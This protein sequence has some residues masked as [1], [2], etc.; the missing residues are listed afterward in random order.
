MGIQALTICSQSTYLTNLKKKHL[1][2]CAFQPT[3][4]SPWHKNAP[5]ARLHIERR[6]ITKVPMTIWRLFKTLSYSKTKKYDHDL[7]IFEFHQTLHKPKRNSFG[8]S[9]GC[10]WWKVKIKQ[11]VCHIVA[12]PFTLKSIWRQKKNYENSNISPCQKIIF[13]FFPK[14]NQNPSRCYD[15]ITTNLKF[16][17]KPKYHLSKIL[18]EK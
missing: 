2:P 12:L 1:N 13:K 8:I 4:I 11:G 18:I 9:N 3:C 5:K 7:E 15:S 16:Q 14:R 17:H 10:A 6:L